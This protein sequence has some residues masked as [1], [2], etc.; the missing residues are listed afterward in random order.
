LTS[1]PDVTQA[2]QHAMPW[3]AFLPLAS[4]AAYLFDGV[5]LGSGKVRWM[6]AT[7]AA[8]A[9]VFALLW[10]LGA[11]TDIPAARNDNLWRAFL[12]FNVCR[13]PCLGAAYA[14]ITTARACLT[15]P[16]A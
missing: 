6:L 15:D 10:W 11:S 7:M 14:R 2:A 9:L 3:V 16:A 4:S 8:S 13:G 12:I 1:L 5:F